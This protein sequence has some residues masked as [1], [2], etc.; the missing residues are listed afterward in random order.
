MVEN[1][2][3]Y[4]EKRR[5]FADQVVY[6]GKIETPKEI[7]GWNLGER[8]KKEEANKTER[9][10]RYYSKKSIKNKNKKRK[11]WPRIRNKMLTYGL[12]A[13]TVW[14]SYKA[15]TEYKDS[16]NTLTLEQALENG[17]T[18][19]ELGINQDIATELEELSTRLEGDLTNQE[20]IE[21]AEE[22]PEI[23]MKVIKTKVANI[24]NIEDWNNDISLKPS[25]G[26]FTTTMYIKDGEKKY[27]R[28][29]IINS[30]VNII[31]GDEKT[32]SPEIANY[33]DAIGRAQG[34]RDKMQGGDIS[35]RDIK[36]CK[37]ALEK[38]SQFA[39][40]KIEIDKK[41]NIGIEKIRVSEW[42]KEQ[43][44]Q[45]ESKNEK[46]DDDGAR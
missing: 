38:A 33:I 11:S 8:K 7:Q 35:E 28:P 6:D 18:L 32:I 21:I 15:Y 41:G 20:L 2:G 9:R 29:G 44:A 4:K 3:S 12:A 14:G 24:L 30:I 26:D 5:A 23:Q 16:Q 31:T 43:K 46:A 40:G 17:E 1:E 34:K 27:E 45:E 22:I 36:N 25:D 39:A 10:E 42:E 19:E 37:N 13:L